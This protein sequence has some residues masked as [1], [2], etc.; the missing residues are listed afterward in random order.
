M[1]SDLY[2]FHWAIPTAKAAADAGIAYFQLIC[3]SVR[4]MVK[5]QPLPKQSFDM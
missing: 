3:V 1:I 2:I 5:P 4:F